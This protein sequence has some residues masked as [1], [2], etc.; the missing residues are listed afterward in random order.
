M[1]SCGVLQNWI[2]YFMIFYLLKIFKDSTEVNIK[3]KQPR[4]S[5]I[6]F[7]RDD[8]EIMSGFIVEGGK[9]DFYDS[10]GI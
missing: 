2:F 3:E 5:C 1:Y 6:R 4:R 7:Y 10:W 9:I 8:R